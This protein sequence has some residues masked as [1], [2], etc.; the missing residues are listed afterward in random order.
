MEI[1]VP[2]HDKSRLKFNRK[3]T[4][5]VSIPPESSPEITKINDQINTSDEN[6]PSSTQTIPVNKEPTTCILEISNYQPL[7]QNKN[8]MQSNV[9]QA[10]S[11]FQG[12]IF[13]NCTINFQMPQN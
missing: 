12:A 5:T 9:C 7:Q 1:D 13:N 11:V 3:P 8:I 4:A 2:K 6:S 10:P